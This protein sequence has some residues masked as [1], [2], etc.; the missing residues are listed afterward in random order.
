LDWKRFPER[1]IEITTKNQ[2][3][4]N[5][6][7]DRVTFFLFVFFLDLRVPIRGTIACDFVDLS[8]ETDRK[9]GQSWDCGV[10]DGQFCRIAKRILEQKY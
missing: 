1:L 7:C 9:F 6:F 3:T 8:L 10:S 5:N 2:I 4:S